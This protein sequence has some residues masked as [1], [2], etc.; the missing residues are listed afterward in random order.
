MK[1]AFNL[2]LIKSV[3]YSDYYLH[4]YG[5]ILLISVLIA[6]DLWQRSTES[7]QLGIQIPGPYPLPIIG[8]AHMAIG[9]K[10]HRRYY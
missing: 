2:T 6:I 9:L 7:W 10:C 8:N 3:I 5:V 4:T 1:M